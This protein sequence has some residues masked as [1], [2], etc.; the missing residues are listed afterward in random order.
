MTLFLGTN[1]RDGRQSD[2]ITS[3]QTMIG[4]CAPAIHPYL[5]AADQLIDMRTGYAAAVP[6]HKII[7]ALTLVFA[8]DLDRYGR[9]DDRCR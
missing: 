4:G 2:S 6:R 7:Q 9:W 8:V 3:G 5:T 1:T